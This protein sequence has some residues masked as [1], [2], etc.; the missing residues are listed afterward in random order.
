M[1]N[2]NSQFDKELHDRLSTEELPFDPMAWEMIEEKLDDEP[3]RR[4][5]FWITRYRYLLGSL[6]ILLI[7][8]ITYW[9]FHYN[10]IQ[11][12]GHSEVV[13]IDDSMSNPTPD[14][15]T[16]S[17]SST[18]TAIPS[19]E[20]S[21][22]TNN[23]IKSAPNYIFSPQQ[24][25]K[26]IKNRVSGE[27]DNVVT[28][29]LVTKN[30]IKEEKEEEQTNDVSTYD[31]II[32][33]TDEITS[34]ITNIEQTKISES[35]HNIISEE[36][37]TLDNIEIEE[38]SI[39]NNT[40]SS[41]F[42]YNREVAFNANIVE[43]A[44]KIDRPK[45]QINMTIGAGMTQLDIDDPIVG[46][47]TP[48]AISK[49]EI[50]LS[51]SYLYRM[52]RNWGIEVGAQAAYQSQTIAHYF[53]EGEYGF[54][55]SEYSKAS[56][57]VFETSHEFFSNIH[58]FLPLNQRSELNIYGGYY[59]FNPLSGQINSGKGTSV[60]SVINNDV[61][62]ILLQATGRSGNIASGKI[63]LGI[64]YN[65]LTNKLNNIG[66]GVA[67]MHQLENVTE[68]NYSLIQTTEE[69]AV[70]GNFRANSSGF[71]VQM[72]YGF[73][74]KQFPWKKKTLKKVSLK[75]KNPWYLGVRYGTKTYKYT[76]DLTRAL[77]RPN[78]NKT[79]SFFVGHYIKQKMA[80]EFG[81]EYSEFVFST[82]TGIN[83]ASSGQ[84][85]VV[86]V[87][88]ALRYDL[89]QSSRISLYGKGVFSTDFRL[90]HERISNISGTGFVTDKNNL[91]L[92]AGIESG[93]DFRIFNSVVIGIMGKYNHAFDRTALVQ[94]PER[95]DQNE[96][97]FRDINLKNTYFSWGVE[98]KYLFNRRRNG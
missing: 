76:D 37:K 24:N 59:A 94:Y 9:S 38:L 80:F 65:F 12:N 49:Q 7:A 52:H 87:P 48:T 44:Q 58:F 93:I 41:I 75:L 68:G 90:T 28:R 13:S 91:L 77:V 51:L 64:N 25:S 98:L 81:L 11:A 2:N 72:T 26:T 69:A 23:T 10:N 55:D 34:G 84:Q 73:G 16:T 5:L 1:N 35:V 53:Q 15:N 22:T 36:I 19:V 88:F 85:K 83:T 27:A 21:P 63:K 66:I 62:L 54:R 29:K 43:I 56:S 39:L 95:N 20:I 70:S 3:K 61:D 47:I 89:L 82:P 96:I 74:R 42:T 86:S 97:V 6:S 79:Q 40:S 92:N 14:M 45:H 67:Y 8:A 60:P 17:D 50:F 18:Y 33:D 30:V 4:Y 31:Q 32:G 46:D 78:T 71:K 57:N